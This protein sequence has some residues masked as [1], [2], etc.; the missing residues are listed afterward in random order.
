M[1]VPT[2]GLKGKKTTDKSEEDLSNDY[3][4]KKSSNQINMNDLMPRVDISGQITES[5]L[6]EL[7]DKNW[8]VC[9]D[10]S[11]FFFFILM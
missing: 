7:A 1:P 6:N 8:K 11:F 4:E 10:V 2:R 5:L 9:R 3:E